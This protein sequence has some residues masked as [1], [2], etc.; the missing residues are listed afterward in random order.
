MRPGRSLVVVAL[1]A[2][3]APSAA[4]ADGWLDAAHASGDWGGVRT[5][6][7]DHGL[8]LELDYTAELFS[9]PDHDDAAYRGDVDLI[10]T[11]ATEKLG[12]WSCGS[13]FVYGQHAHGRGVSDDFLPIMPVSNLEAPAFTQLS[14]LWLDQCLGAHVRLRLGKQDA[15]RDFAGPRFGGNFINSSYGVAPPV[16]MPSFPA[17][18]LGAVVRADVASWL[19]ARAGV[20]EGAPT[21]HSFG[22]H[23]LDDGAFAVGAL[24][25]EHEL[26]GQPAGNH[27]LGVWT[28]TGQHRSG[29]FGVLDLQ[30]RAHPDDR[31]DS[32]SVQL[33]VRGGWSEKIVGQVYLYAG[34]GL[35]VHGYLGHDN[36]LG[37]GAGH[38]RVDDTDETF[39]ELFFKWRP[40]PWLTFEPDAQLYSTAAGE[41]FALG[42]RG[43]LKL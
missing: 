33:F 28:H 3:V 43:K 34:G 38:A 13:L 11:F 6:L 4:R 29:I 5:W 39:V 30:L 23:A 24:V 16:P 32:R 25:F 40:A 12:L 2:F 37:L 27:Q 20:Y 15:N 17:P 36:T 22:E 21:I 26:F 9:L 1:V 19:G 8:D 10:A 7:A 18:G 31:G 14:E 41:E 42:L 35:T